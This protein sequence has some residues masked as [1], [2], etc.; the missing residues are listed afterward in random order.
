[1]QDRYS[2]IGIAGLNFVPR[3]NGTYRGNDTSLDDFSG[4]LMFCSLLA[5]VAELTYF[6]KRG[7]Y[8]RSHIK[9]LKNNARNVNCAHEK[10]CTKV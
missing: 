9:C 6:T 1:M 7:I 5:Y 8:S 10:L 2:D 4:G 3:K